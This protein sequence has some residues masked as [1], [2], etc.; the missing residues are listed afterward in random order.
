MEIK[1]FAM[2]VKI[3]SVRFVSRVPWNAS[4]HENFTVFFF[5]NYFHLNKRKLAIYELKFESKS[6]KS[7]TNLFFLST[8]QYVSFL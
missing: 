2:S 1:D 5:K 7:F 6:F 4:K 3:I 8:H